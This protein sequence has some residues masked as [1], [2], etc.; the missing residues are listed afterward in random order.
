MITTI[1]NNC[2]SGEDVITNYRFFKF[3]QY[4]LF[5]HSVADNFM[6]RSGLSAPSI[7]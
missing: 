2:G 6:R 4:H 5:S 3:Y 1:K 7:L